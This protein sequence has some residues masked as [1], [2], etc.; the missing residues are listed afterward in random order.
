MEVAKI[1]VKE[2]KAKLDS[3]ER[4]G[5]LDVRNPTAWGDSDVKLPGALRIAMDDLDARSEVF[6]PAFAVV[7]YC[8]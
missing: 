7:A 1:T 4:V 8:T 6:N 3:G 5:L 2:L